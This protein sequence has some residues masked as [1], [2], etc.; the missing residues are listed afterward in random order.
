[1]RIKGVPQ[2]FRASVLPA[3]LGALA[4]LWLFAACTTNNGHGGGPDTCGTDQPDPDE[5]LIGCLVDEDDNPI[6]GV[7][8]RATRVKISAAKR[9]EAMSSAE[10]A[11][12]VFESSVSDARGKYAFE[13]LDTGLYVLR[14]VDS[15]GRS[16]PPTLKQVQGKA[17]D[18]DTYVLVRTGTIRGTVKDSVTG[19]PLDRMKCDIPGLPYGVE[20]DSGGHFTLLVPMGQ[21]ALRCGEYP[22]R[23]S[24]IDGLKVLPGL[25]TE[26]DF[27]LMLK[28]EVEVRPPPPSSVTIRYD[29]VTGIVHLSW[30]KVTFKKP[31]HYWLRRIDPTALGPDSDP[32]APYFTQWTTADTFWA[33]VVY[34]PKAESNGTKAKVPKVLTYNIG[35]TLATEYAYS[36]TWVEDTVTA[37]PPM[38]LGPAVSVKAVDTSS[39]YT[40][41]DTAILVGEYHNPFR[42]NKK[43]SWVMEG[44]GIELQGKTLS[45]KDGVDTLVYPCIVP[46]ASLRITLRV[47][48]EFGEVGSDGYG[49]QVKAP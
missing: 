19:E 37:T 10:A 2:G 18:P 11:D 15:A 13:D 6:A 38:F 39:V 43:L 20:T 17:D 44:T 8:V 35:A 47:T 24:Q 42:V 25:E 16:L 45:G 4:A 48:D 9:S 30:P 36:K 3:W 41:G 21:Y 1:M 5:D 7:T 33:D 49:F 46:S 12:S 31:V 34:W 22:Y 26:A 28:T 27:H 32:K 40:A 14:A 29:K 23:V